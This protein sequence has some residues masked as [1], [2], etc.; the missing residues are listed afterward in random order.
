MRLSHV[1][2]IIFT[3]SDPRRDAALASRGP[4]LP[5]ASNGRSRGTAHPPLR[6]R[7]LLVEERAFRNRPARSGAV[8]IPRGNTA[9]VITRA[10]NCSY[11]IASPR[12]QP[13]VSPR[14]SYLS[15]LPVPL[16]RRSDG[17]PVLLSAQK[18]VK[19]EPNVA[20]CSGPPTDLAASV[21]PCVPK[22]VSTRSG[23]Q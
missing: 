14:W 19:R 2:T 3:T 10:R 4:P 16:A 23:I 5:S 7:I 8:P 20:R 17:T 13:R 6:G 15:S 22:L 9:I 11:D 18:P 12:L 1:C 21:E